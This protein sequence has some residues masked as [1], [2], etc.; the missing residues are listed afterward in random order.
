MNRMHHDSCTI[1]RLIA[2]CTGTVIVKCK[3]WS[4]LKHCIR[5]AVPCCLV[6]N[7]LAARLTHVNHRKRDTCTAAP[8]AAGAAAPAAAANV[9]RQ[10]PGLSGSVIRTTSQQG[11][12]SS[13]LILEIRLHTWLKPCHNSDA[14]AAA[15][16]VCSSVS[17]HGN[18]WRQPMQLPAATSNTFASALAPQP[19]ASLVQTQCCPHIRI[20]SDLHLY[21]RLAQ[22]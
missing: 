15:C 13:C 19:H 18:R 21:I 12:H 22:S 4:K 7:G 3:Y 16:N 8:A 6:P 14:A 11:P 17:L 9:I 10:Q 1:L 5:A 20:H 2:S